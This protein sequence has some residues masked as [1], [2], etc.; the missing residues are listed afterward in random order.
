MSLLDRL[1]HR[2][3]PRPACPVHDIHCH[4]LPGVDDGA[5]T[6]DESLSILRAL[7]ALGVKRVTCTPH[8][9]FP[10]LMNG[11]GNLEPVMD[12]LRERVMAAGI[13]VA[14]DLGA[15]YR[16]GEHLLDLIARGEILS[17]SDGRVLVEHDFLSPSPFFERVT[18]ELL[19]R[20]HEVVLAHPERY[21]FWRGDLVERCEEARSRGC[22]LQVNLLSLAGYHGVEARRGARKLVKAGLVDYL[23]GDVH[24]VEQAGVIARYLKG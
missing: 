5:R 6:V 13:D 18:F 3:V 23:A 1:L 22:K 20:G 24:R 12:D 15:E 7:S 4:A 10:S 9:W 21:P 19:S 16:V 2:E 8:V 17:G 11:R 14:L